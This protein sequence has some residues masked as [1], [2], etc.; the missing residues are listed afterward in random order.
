MMGFWPA[1]VLAYNEDARTLQLHIPRL[2]DGAP[3]GITAQIAYPIGDDDRDTELAISEG[4]DVWVFFEGGD[5]SRPVAFASRG[6]GTGTVAGTRRIRQQHIELLADESVLLRC[7]DSGSLLLTTEQLEINAGGVVMNVET[8]QILGTLQ[9][10]VAIINGMDVMKH[11]HTYQQGAASVPTS[12]PL[13]I[14]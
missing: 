8:T 13:P 2:T 3:E 4:L 11:V 5:P 6:H 12:P 10:L 1:R 9:A 14:P 7:G